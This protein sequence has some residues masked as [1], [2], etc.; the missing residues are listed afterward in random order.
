MIARL[1]NCTLLLIVPFLPHVVTAQEFPPGYV[2]PA[3]V[4]R[5]AADFY[6]A[7]GVMCLQIAARPEAN[8]YAG[9]VGQARFQSDDWPR[10]ESLQNYVRTF[11]W[12]T[13]TQIE[14][15]TRT[16]GQNPQG[17]KYGIGWVGGSPS[18]VHEQQ[19]FIVSGDQA[20]YH[21]GYGEEQ[22][23]SD[24]IPMP[25]MAA[26]WQLDMWMNP[27][28]F[29]R[30]AELPG[31]NPRAVWRWELPESGR[32][33]SLTGAG[34]PG[35]AERVHVVFID[36]PHIGPDYYI[37]ATIDSQNRFLRFFSF[38]PHPI[39][40]DLLWEQEHSFNH[41]VVDGVTWPIGW[42][43][44]QL[45][46][47]ERGWQVSSGGHNA[48]GGNIAEVRPHEC[49]ATE[50]LEVPPAV[51][52]ATAQIPAIPYAHEVRVEVHELA[53]GIYLMGGGTHNSVAIEFE[54]FIVVVEAPLNEDRSLAVIEEIVRI[55]PD[56][57]IRYVVN[58]HDHYDHIGGLRTYL[59][60]GATTITHIW[61]KWF[62][63]YKVL[64]RERRILNPDLL[65]R[66]VQTEIREGNV[67][68]L[69]QENYWISDGDRL[70]HINYIGYPFSH[71]EGMLIA[72]LPEEGIL[73]QAD[74]FDTHVPPPASPSQ[75]ANTLYR[76]VT[77]GWDWPLETLV[78]IHGLPVPWSEFEAY[79]T[80]SAEDRD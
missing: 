64:N 33:G 16:P 15:F 66:D 18:Q 27:I 63:Y 32:D 36:L 70:L 5:A 20:W 55:I 60:I 42:H 71:A 29:L 30:A 69:V 6:G 44:H 65:S 24:A 9:A 57:P 7:D 47:D 61:N 80:Q 3:P 78:P 12:E 21:D 62:Y 2:D 8:I 58:T 59:H 38:V 77:E 31:A 11:N 73:I 13:R 49:G 51:Q 41:E 52:A 50:G 53:D 23:D 19:G 46:D 10:Q 72:V 76:H 79:V 48:F 28:G 40:G 4:L 34:R 43:H 35:A 1:V 22:G 56:K 39:F 54:D 68:E 45:W 37:S 17:W 75:A 25:D 74:M 67:Y 26:A 14:S